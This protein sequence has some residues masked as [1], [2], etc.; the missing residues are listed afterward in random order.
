M[1]RRKLYTDAEKKLLKHYRNQIYYYG[2]QLASHSFK[3]DFVITFKDIRPL[4]TREE[5]YPLL[6]I[7]GDPES[8]YV[9][10]FRQVA[11]DEGGSIRAHIDKI[12]RRLGYG[13]IDQ[14]ENRNKRGQDLKNKLDAAVTAYEKIRKS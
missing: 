11:I 12:S 10:D 7:F 3:Y 2:K 13:S 14:Y 5:V 4:L 1:G 9:K 8:Y 6:E